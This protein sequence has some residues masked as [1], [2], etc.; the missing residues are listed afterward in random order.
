MY[1]LKPQVFI[2]WLKSLQEVFSRTMVLTRKLGD[3]VIKTSEIGSLNTKIFITIIT[4]DFTV[5][6]GK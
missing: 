5:K 6:Y 2:N 4:K 3:L 1:R